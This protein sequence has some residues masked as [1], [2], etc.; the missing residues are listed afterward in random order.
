M[1]CGTNV[2]DHGDDDVE[3]LVMAPGPHQ[4]L[5]AQDGDQDDGVQEEARHG[6]TNQ[7]RDYDLVTSLNN[8]LI[9]C[10]I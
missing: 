7:Q 8:S 4:Q 3:I 10:H 5:G 9:F 6:Q 1:V 2:T